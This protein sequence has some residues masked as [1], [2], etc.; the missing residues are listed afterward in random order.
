MRKEVSFKESRIVGTTILLLGMGFL[1]SVVPKINLVVMMFNLLLALI[2]GFLFYYFWKTTKHKSKRYYSL[3]SFVMVNVMA[4]QFAIPLLRIYFLT[5]TFWIGIVMIIIMITLPYLYSREIAFGVQK[6]GK[7]K[8][9]KIY[10]IYLA[11]LFPFGGTAFMS[12]LYTSNP[13]AIVIAVI[14]FLIALL[15]LFLAPIFLIKPAEMNQ[16]TKN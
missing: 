13:D 1:A 11:M 6:P 2:G 12:S 7:S 4:I 3:L 16:I 15:F 9:G 5:L 8:L 10:L 14:T